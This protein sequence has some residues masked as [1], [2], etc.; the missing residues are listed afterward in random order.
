MGVVPT[1]NAS[2]EPTAMRRA[3]GLACPMRILFSGRISGYYGNAPGL[4]EEAIEE[5]RAGGLVLPLPAFGGAACEVAIALGLVTSIEIHYAEYGRA[6]HET[7]ALLQELSLAHRKRATSGPA[8]AASTLSE[9]HQI[10]FHL[11][12]ILA[13]LREK[14]LQRFSLSLDDIAP[15]GP[16]FRCQPN[17]GMPGAVSAEVEAPAENRVL[18]LAD[19]N[20]PCHR[21]GVDFVAGSCF[22]VSGFG[23]PDACNFPLNIQDAKSPR[24]L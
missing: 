3:M 8:C 23:G 18:K 15:L 7:F 10:V 2:D 9:P 17:G 24:R 20:E 19:K 11:K 14:P 5:I 6:Y 1:S 12:Q 16:E 4:F 21:M 13:I 22:E